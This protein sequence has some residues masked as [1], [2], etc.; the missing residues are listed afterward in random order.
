[1]FRR[2]HTSGDTNQRRAGPFYGFFMGTDYGIQ[3]GARGKLYVPGR[4]LHGVGHGYSGVEHHKNDLRRVLH[5][6]VTT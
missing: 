2:R 4:E 5:S 1:M 3:S 6:C